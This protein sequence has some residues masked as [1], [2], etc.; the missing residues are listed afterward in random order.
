MLTYENMESTVPGLEPL[1]RRL[2]STLSPARLAHSER[3]ADVARRLAQKFGAD[4]EEAGIAG[5]GHDLAREWSGPELVNYAQTHE[6]PA[7]SW[8]FETPVFLHGIVAAQIL[9]SE[10]GISSAD[11]LAAVRHHTLGA[12]NLPLLGKILYAADYLEPGRRH[13]REDE[14][15]DLLDSPSV[16]TMLRRILEKEMANRGRLERSTQDMYEEVRHDEA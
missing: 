16:E 12:R 14:R 6:L 7:E 11:V 10:F 2:R 3:V 5:L 15:Q 1:Y 8:E 13:I 9:A 4:T